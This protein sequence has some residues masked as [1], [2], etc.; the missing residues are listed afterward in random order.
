MPTSE[1]NH[2][3]LRPPRK[4][5]CNSCTKSKVRCSLEKPTC[6][7]CRSTGRVCEYSASALTRD[8]SPG[9]RAFSEDAGAGYPGSAVYSTPRFDSASAMPIPLPY[10]DTPSSTAWSP[11]SQFHV[12]RSGASSWTNRDGLDFKTVDLVPSANAED[13]RDRWLRPYILPPLGREEVP[14]VYHPFT[15]QYISRVLSTYPRYMLKDRDVPPMIHRSQI[16]GKELP[17]SLANCY[18]LV[19]MWE[20]AVPGSEMMVM[21]TLEKEMERLNEERP[22]HDYEL[23]SAFQAYLLY[24]IML[25]FSPRGGLSLVNDKMMITLMEM[26]FRTARNGIFCAAE[27]AHTRPTW[28]SWIVVAAK[29]RAIFT[30]YLFSSVYNADRLLPNFVADEMRGVYAPGNK[31]LWEARDREAWSREYDRY[32]LRWEDGML[33]ISELWRSAETGSAERRERIERWVQSADE[34]GM[35]L[36]GVCAHIHG[37]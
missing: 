30:M 5:A 7:R 24:T 22:K 14:K 16:G 35:M 32:L 19:R 26:A 36:F 12:W 23:L 1:S 4:K 34:F 28:E 31:A 9:E 11:S 29:R 2:S 10:A 27:L 37:C 25:Y 15:L 33:E 6:S 20:Q 13:I 21:S 18:S 3:K 17:R 8:T